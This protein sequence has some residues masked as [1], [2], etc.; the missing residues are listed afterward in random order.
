MAYQIRD[1]TMECDPMSLW[2]FIIFI[3]LSMAFIDSREIVDRDDRKQDD[4]EG[5]WHATKDSSPGLEP[6]TAAARTKS[7]YVGCLI[8]QLS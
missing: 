1:F 5:E 8:Y 4:R 3:G 6:G 2:I 7:L